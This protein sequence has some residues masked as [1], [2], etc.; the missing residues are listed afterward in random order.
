MELLSQ[1]AGLFAYVFVPDYRYLIGAYLI[2]CFMVGLGGLDRRIGFWGHFL[3]SV[4]FTPI[5]G[6]IVLCTSESRPKQQ[7]LTK[8]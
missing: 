1:T 5:V 7:Q 3:I 6:V 8:R 2:I 4:V